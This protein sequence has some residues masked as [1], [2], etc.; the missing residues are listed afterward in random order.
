M[1]PKNIGR[2]HILKAIEEIRK[3]GVPQGRGSR[4][5]LIEF[6]G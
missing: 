5:F 6:N 4:K 2:E 1:I 3:K